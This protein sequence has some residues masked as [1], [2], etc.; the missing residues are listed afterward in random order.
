VQGPVIAYVSGRIAFVEEDAVVVD[1]GG[2]GYRVFVPD[3][4]RAG[5]VEETSVQLYTYQHVR[6]D[7]VLLYGF[8][9]MEERR[10]FVKLLDAGGVGPKLGLAILSRLDG[11][12][13]V[14]AIRAEDWS[15]LTAVPGVGAKTAQRIALELKDKLDDL[16]A[17]MGAPAGMPLAGTGSA[18][19][20]RPRQPALP[21]SLLDARD[22]LMALG[23]SE[24]EATEALASLEPELAEGGNTAQAVRLALRR[25]GR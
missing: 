6:E 13:V 25:L 23:Y 5:A 9:S 19:Q 15:A 22:A 7:A 11:R 21:P 4:L 20:R 2:V 3:P 1:V 18:A 24:K 10:L 17:V 12:A 16:A 8:A 14:G